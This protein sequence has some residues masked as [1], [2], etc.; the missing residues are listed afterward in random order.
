MDETTLS[1]HCWA[2]MF[3]Y[4]DC[5]LELEGK[6]TSLHE[7]NVKERRR[8]KMREGARVSC[9]CWAYSESVVEWSGW[10]HQECD[11]SAHF[12]QV[13]RNV[14]ISRT[15]FPNHSVQKYN[16]KFIW[17]GK[18]N[19][20]KHG[21]LNVVLMLYYL[22]IFIFLHLT[23]QWAANIQHPGTNPDLS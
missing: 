5:W 6:R 1:H 4:V 21:K 10:C 14:K 23:Q 2:F 18:E 9:E 16:Q 20:R 22:F 17:R 11:K 19:P 7:C 13:C 8:R 15:K 3:C 12:T